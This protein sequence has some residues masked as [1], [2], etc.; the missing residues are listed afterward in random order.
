MGI[1]RDR[2]IERQI[3]R[4]GDYRPTIASIDGM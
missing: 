3:E 4:E 1:N 2:E